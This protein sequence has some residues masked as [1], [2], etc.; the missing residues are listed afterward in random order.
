MEVHI[1]GEQLHCCATNLQKVLLLS[2]ITSLLSMSV[3]SSSSDKRIPRIIPQYHF[4]D[5]RRRFYWSRRRSF[6]RTIWYWPFCNSKYYQFWDYHLKERQVICH[7]S[8]RS[9]FG[10]WAVFPDRIPEN[11][12]FYL[13]GW[14]QW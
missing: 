10:W 5:F 9:T 4:W 6:C 1:P 7:S 3:K 14:R 13:S 8:R 2:V 11:R 12:T